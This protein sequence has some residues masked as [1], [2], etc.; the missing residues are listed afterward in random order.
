MSKITYAAL[1]LIGAVPGAYLSYLLVMAMLGHFGDMA[2]MM[3]VL[4]CGILA[5]SAL[6]AAMPVGIMIFVRE[7][8]TAK[9]T[10]DED[11]EEVEEVGEVDDVEPVAEAAGEIPD[12]EAAG[13]VDSEESVM[14]E[15]TGEVEEIEELDDIYEADEEPKKK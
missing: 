3:R 7:P 1:S 11:A 2:G 6:L 13:V 9:P 14:I 5:L 10:S 12:L 4:A 8:G 15:S